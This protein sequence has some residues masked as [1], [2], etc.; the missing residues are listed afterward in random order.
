M[1]NIGGKQKRDGT[2][3]S[4]KK[5]RRISRKKQNNSN[6]SINRMDEAFLRF[7][8]LPEQIFEKFDNKSLVNLRVV[9]ATWCVLRMLLMT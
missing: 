9:G 2:S 6:N 5:Q 1:E 3:E 7:P 8:H 4:S